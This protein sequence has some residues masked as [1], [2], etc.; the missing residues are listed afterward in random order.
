MRQGS[1]PTRQPRQQSRGFVLVN[2]LVLV[3]ALSAVS[4]ALLSRA[5]G[6]R[7]RMLA[8]TDAVQL[9]LY[10]DAYEALA[11]AILNADTNAV[12]HTREA[13]ARDDN[14]LTLD[15][16]QVSGRLQDLQGRFNLN[17]LANPED[18]AA[19]EAFERLLTQLGVSTQVGEQILAA[20]RPGGSGLTKTGKASVAENLPGGTALMLDQLAIPERALRRL[21]SHIAVLPGDSQLNVNTTSALVLTSFLSGVNPVA[22]DA[23]LSTRRTEPF[24]SMDDFA[25]R[26]VQIMGAESAEA[27]D[28]D[29][30]SVG[31][32][33]F[34]VRISAKLEGR[35]ATR[36]VV[37]QRLSL[38][39]GAQVAY[40][41]DKW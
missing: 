26:L 34:E 38:P 27:L 9:E 12:D 17:W 11:R 35:T 5:E 7:L 25:D 33:W 28:T 4:L 30:L 10:L 23:L 15:R 41:L 24:I 36:Q 16:G 32:E 18:I 29:R 3:A 1:E 2:A 20:L 13:W 14:A 40:R 19:R 21:R 39:A 6:G 31:S 37:L 22:L 8:A